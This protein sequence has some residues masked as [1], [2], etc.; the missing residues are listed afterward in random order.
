MEGGAEP[1]HQITLRNRQVVLALLD[2]VAGRGG[3]GILRDIYADQI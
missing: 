2:L 1:S 3:G